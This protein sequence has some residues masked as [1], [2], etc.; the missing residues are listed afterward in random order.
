MAKNVLIITASLRNNSSTDI[1]AEAFAKGAMKSGHNVEKISLK[2]KEINFC[3]ACYY[4][5]NINRCIQKDDV[6]GVLD[7]LIN[8]DVV[9]FATPVYFYEMSGVLKTFLDRTMPAYFIPCKFKEVYI[10]TAS[11]DTDV[12]SA[13]NIINGIQGW[14]DCFEGV[15]LCG[16][17]FAEGA[18]K[19]GDAEHHS[20]LK[21]A[22]NMGKNI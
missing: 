3:K 11:T 18:S 15:K 2:N 6:N 12:H 22:F 1:L 13:D 17:V 10:L 16:T 21:N 7:K 19:P 20:A 5:Q 9:V 14:V 8:T 4:C